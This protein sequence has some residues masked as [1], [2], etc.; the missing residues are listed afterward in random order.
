MKFLFL[1]IAAG[2]AANVLTWLLSRRT[3]LPPVSGPPRYRVALSLGLYA[4]LAKSTPAAG[5]FFGFMGGTLLVVPVVFLSEALAPKL[6]LPHH[7]D[8]VIVSVFLLLGTVGGTIL[9]ARMGRKARAAELPHLEIFG[10]RVVVPRRGPLDIA[11]QTVI[12]FAELTSVSAISDDILIVTGKRATAVVRAADIV[13][14]AS[15]PGIQAEIEAAA[16]DSVDGASLAHR[17]EEEAAQTRTFAER[18][19]TMTLTV[20]VL[21][22]AIYVL[23]LFVAGRWTA[24]L[25]RLGANFLHSWESGHA[26]RLVTANFLHAS[27]IHIVS[28]LGAIG[29]FGVIVEKILGTSRAIVIY[30]LSC[31]VGAF[32]SSLVDPLAVGASTGVFGLMTAAAVVQFLQGSRLPSTFQIDRNSWIVM[33]GVNAALPLFIPNISWAGHLGGAITGAAVAAMIAR[34]PRSIDGE[35]PGVAVRALAALLIVVHLGAFV[36]AAHFALRPGDFPAIQIPDR[37]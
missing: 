17:L 4:S 27:L 29:T 21:L 7:A 18:S 37:R 30:G 3:D 12:P 32:V 5:P 35:R 11:V 31:I 20:T 9:G 1:L 10:D 19:S 14:V 16:R 33:F 36:R 23:Q 25:V 13:S 8:G 26:Y 2:V 22:V 24:T 6:G 15:V 28:N 34:S